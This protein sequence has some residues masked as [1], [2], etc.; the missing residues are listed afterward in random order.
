[1]GSVL[2][3]LGDTKTMVAHNTV[4]WAGGGAITLGLLIVMM[5]LNII[6]LIGPFLGMFVA[7]VLAT[8]II[9]LAYAARNGNASLDDFTASV[10]ENYVTYLLATLLIGAA[11]TAVAFVFVI[12]AV[13]LVFV[14][15]TSGSGMEG[16]EAFFASM[17]LAMMLLFVV[18]FL[19][20][21][22]VGLAIQFFDVA[23]V[24]DDAGP[25]D[26]FKRSLSLIKRAP[27]SVVGYTLMRSV[28]GGLVIG[29]PLA[30]AFL[31]L[32]GSAFAAGGVDG[33]ESLGLLPLIGFAVWGLVVLPI[34]NVIMVTYH[35]AFYNRHRAAGTI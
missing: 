20:T 23:I 29:V 15:S 8:G 33:G 18:V 11:Y 31:L 4:L 19:L 22:L 21:F 17:G 34:G 28:L 25:I 12:V 16:G 26:A 24:I 2:D 5:G 35:V 9:G 10:S 30:G 6:P 14:G 32:F 1:M 13:I 3:A 7:P 27:L